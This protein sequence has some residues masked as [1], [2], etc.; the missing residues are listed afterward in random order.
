MFEEFGQNDCVKRPKPEVLDA[1][2]VPI[3]VG[4]VV[5]NKNAV[6]FRV[7]DLNGIGITI[8]LTRIESD[9]SFCLDPATLTHEEPDSITRIVADALKGP[10]DYFESRFGQC[11]DCQAY[12]RLNKGGCSAY[13]A[14]DLLRRQREVLERDHER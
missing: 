3:K 8:K 6:A 4:D 7:D 11:E 1:D 10:C 13:Q 5:Y 12:D 9:V 2:G 14:L